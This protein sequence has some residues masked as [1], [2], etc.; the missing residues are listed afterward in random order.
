[1][2]LP[3]PPPARG[4][5]GPPS[6]HAA[7]PAIVPTSVRCPMKVLRLFRARGAGV[8]G[9]S[10]CSIN[11]LDRNPGRF[12]QACPRLRHPAAFGHA[13]NRLFRDHVWVEV[14]ARSGI[15]HC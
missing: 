3:G 14:L 15:S 13:R 4:A 11:L 1:M 7:V 9:W 2:P 6:D 12:A 5:V 8:N 10:V